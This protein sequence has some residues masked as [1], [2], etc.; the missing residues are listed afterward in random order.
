MP[1]SDIFLPKGNAGRSTVP[2]SDIFLPKG[3]AARS[4]VFYQNT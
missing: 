2:V 4:T 1:V 3:N